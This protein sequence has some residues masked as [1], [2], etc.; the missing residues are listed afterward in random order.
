[1]QNTVFI[2]ELVK[3]SENGLPVFVLVF[4]MLMRSLF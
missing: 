1:M 4:S 2:V 3:C